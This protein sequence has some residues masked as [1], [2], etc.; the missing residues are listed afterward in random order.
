MLAVCIGYYLHS[1]YSCVNENFFS[2]F[3]FS[4][5]LASVVP[6]TTTT[7]KKFFLHSEISRAEVY[8]SVEKEHSDG[9]E[10]KSRAAF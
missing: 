6:K 7:H 5:L 10:S 4:P 2:S 9:K 1:S 8:D 3:F